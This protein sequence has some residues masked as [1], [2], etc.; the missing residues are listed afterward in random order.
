MT[1]TPGCPPARSSVADHR[2]DIVDRLRLGDESAFAE[3]VTAWSPAMLRVAGRYVSTRA[4]AEEVVQETWVGVLHG[5]DEFQRRSTLRTWV[6]RILVNIATSRGARERKVVP[7]SALCTG[8]SGRTTVDPDRF[9]PLKAED[10]DQWTDAGRQRRWESGPEAT[11]LRREIRR[12]LSSAIEQLPTQQRI[13]VGMR[14]MEGYTSAD[15]CRLLT[16]SAANQRVLLHRARARLR[17]V[18][19]TSVG[20]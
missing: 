2:S 6:F 5:L 8:G 14:D 16:I 15:V 1:A 12:Q 10:S 17:A 13:V 4:S 7:L 11:L 20:A 9:Q 19:K 3:I 18:L